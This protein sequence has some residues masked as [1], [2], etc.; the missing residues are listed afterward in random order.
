MSRQGSPS[1]SDSED[2]SASPLGQ[3][4]SFSESYKPWELGFG[5]VL[6]SFKVGAVHPQGS[7]HSPPPVGAW[8]SCVL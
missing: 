5:L 4:R 7:L 6:L 8:G 1:D 2:V 3:K